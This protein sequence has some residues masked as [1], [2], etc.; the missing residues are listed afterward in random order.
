VI[1]HTA[2]R[3][4]GTELSELESFARSLDQADP[5]AGF[6]DRFE[7]PLGSEGAPLVYLVGNSLGPL[8]RA[9]R[10][11]VGSQLD[12]WGRS[13]VDGWFEQPEPWYGL[14]ERWLDPL[15]RLVGCGRHEVAVMNGL[16]VNL[17]LLLASFFRPHGARRKILIESPCF[18]SD[19]FAVE[20]QLR[21]HGLDPDECLIE[22]GAG[23]NSALI[24]ERQ[25]E[26]ALAEHGH[27]IAV[28]L[29]GGVNFLTG[30]R[31]DL[32]RL[33]RATHAV[34]AVFGVDLAHA[35]ANVPLR[36]HDWNVDFAVWCHY[37]YVNGGPGAPGGAF[38]H[39]RHLAGG[40][41]PRLGGWWGNDPETRFRMQ[42]EPAYVP[43]ND[44]AGWQL[45]CPSVL[46]MAPL[47]P[48]LELID[49]AGLDRLREKSM[50]LTAY[51][52][53]LLKRIP[54]G[55]LQILTPSDPERRGAQL[56]MRIDRG[57]SAFQ[58]RLQEAGVVGDFR[59]PDVLRLA[60]APL[61]NS[62]HDMWRAAEG[63]RNA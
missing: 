47:G 20:T 60:P 29:L 61:F 49:E 39:D 3:L 30:Q 57:T 37:K 14:D 8:P 2:A 62:F 51:L 23:P 63:V 32:E 43:R 35:V 42:L 19:R 9:A 22:I 24:D 18:P 36:L 5:L 41:L 25:F 13:G 28:F 6:R 55:R 12:R 53:W 15:S 38:V 50:R 59:E 21:W 4:F 11:I 46:A 31:F 1:R 54:D 16:T 52:E 17:H 44:A 56:S 58:V 45:S 34:D 40:P 27:E 10:E 33:A 26:L 48:A 7:L